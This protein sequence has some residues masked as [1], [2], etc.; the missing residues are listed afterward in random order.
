LFE[1]DGSGWDPTARVM[2]IGRRQMP[3]AGIPLELFSL[4]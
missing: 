3:F 1:D 4:W 2:V